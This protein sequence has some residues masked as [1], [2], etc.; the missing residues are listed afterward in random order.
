[1]R[2]AGEK[3]SRCSTA[4]INPL[5]LFNGVLARARK[6]GVW[7]RWSHGELKAVPTGVK[8]RMQGEGDRD[9]EEMESMLVMKSEVQVVGLSGIVRCGHVPG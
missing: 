8:Q 9:I 4:G 2:T 5:L 3:E 6:S 1:M 7:D